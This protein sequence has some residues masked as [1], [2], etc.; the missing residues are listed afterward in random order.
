[1]IDSPWCPHRKEF[2]RSE[3]ITFRSQ[4]IVV[5]ESS[6]NAVQL[7]LI[8]DFKQLKLVCEVKSK[9]LINFMLNEICE[10]LKFNVADNGNKKLT[11]Q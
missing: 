1:M 7:I 5:A 10:K 6:N 9:F 4:S 8:R 2:S 3:M 11:F